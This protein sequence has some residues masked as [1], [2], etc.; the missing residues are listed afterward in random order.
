M[1]GR[2]GPEALLAYFK[3][4]TTR[5]RHWDGAIT[6]TNATLPR[7][8]DVRLTVRRT[9][10]HSAAINSDHDGFLRMKLINDLL[11]NIKRQLPSL[12]FLD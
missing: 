10:A 5:F 8:L 9:I 4:F 7:D 12:M 2:S 11:C 3:R 6:R 1:F